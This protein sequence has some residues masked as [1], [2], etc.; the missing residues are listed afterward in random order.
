MKKNKIEL[1]SELLI[2]PDGRILVQNLT[3][4]FAE[5]LKEL[6][7]NEEQISSRAKFNVGQASS[8]SKEPLKRKIDRQDACPTL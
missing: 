6:N 4:P 7:P 5:L 1:N 2:L 8:L 3:Q